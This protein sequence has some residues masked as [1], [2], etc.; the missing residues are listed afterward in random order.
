ML[1]D[2]K[3]TKLPS[4][5]EMDP[6]KVP[7]SQFPISSLPPIQDFNQIC[8]NTASEFIDGFSY[9]ETVN[10]KGG[11]YC[12]AGV[13]K[14]LIAVGKNPCKKRIRVPVINLRPKL[15]ARGLRVHGGNPEKA[16][17]YC[18]SQS[19][20]CGA[21]VG[22]C[23]SAYNMY[24]TVYDDTMP[25]HI[26]LVKPYVNEE[27][28]RKERKEKERMVEKFRENMSEND[29]TPTPTPGP[30][31]GCKGDDC[32][33]NCWVVGIVTTILVLLFVIFLMYSI[34]TV[35]TAK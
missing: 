12:K 17:A 21:E 34:M 30:G 5:F 8:Y 13:T 26:P 15:F 4:I 27:G 9:D 19:N 6:S 25:R 14:L 18:I 32:G 23:T 29:T 22:F 2:I 24:K 11:Q 7:I 16:K 31:P 28:K 1:V 3:M 20:N 35:S 10:S 33:A